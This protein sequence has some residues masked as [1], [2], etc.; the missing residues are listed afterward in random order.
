[1]LAGNRKRCQDTEVLKSLGTSYRALVLGASGALGR[2]FVE[3]LQADA[4][5]A[6]VVGLSRTSE[7]AF[8]LEDEGSIA[9]AATSLHLHSGNQLCMS[10]LRDARFLGGAKP[11]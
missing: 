3:A 5:C 9:A 11:Y 4:T 2:A 8:R 6:E 1:M 10:D 7:P